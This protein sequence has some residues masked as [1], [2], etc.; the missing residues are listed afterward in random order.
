MGFSIILINI[1]RE[2]VASYKEDY[3][4]NSGGVLD[5]SYAQKI[6]LPPKNLVASITCSLKMIDITQLVC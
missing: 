4:W 5:L 1:E 6:E 2:N 3:S